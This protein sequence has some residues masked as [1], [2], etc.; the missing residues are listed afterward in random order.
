MEIGYTELRDE[1]LKVWLW[2]PQRD[3]LLA[4]ERYWAPT[5]AEVEDLV[6]NTFI[7]EY[8]YTIEMMDC[9]DFSLILH[10]F[11]IQYRYYFMTS[12]G[13]SENQ[14]LPWPFGQVWLTKAQGVVKNHAQNICFTR[15]EG[16]LLIEP[17]SSEFYVANNETDH[18]F[19]IR[20]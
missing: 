2:F 19:H 18:P 15:D 5:R 7:D 9:E 6:V 3:I 14:R 10:A 20:I 11:I 12:H 4:D 1:V 17:Q 16:M 13:L 8:Q